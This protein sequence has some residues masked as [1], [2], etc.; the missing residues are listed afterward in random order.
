MIVIYRTTIDQLELSITVYL[1]IM[2]ICLS[3]L[4]CLSYLFV[5]VLIIYMFSIVILLNNIIIDV[6]RIS[7]CSS[8]ANLFPVVGSPTD[9]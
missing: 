2:F 3:C 7:K 4:S 9:S 8:I 6:V 5:I 1:S